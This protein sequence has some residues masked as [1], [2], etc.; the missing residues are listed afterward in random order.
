M[1]FCAPHSTAAYLLVPPPS[2]IS[3]TFPFG[4]DCPWYKVQADS[5]EAANGRVLSIFDDGVTYK[6]CGRFLKTT[7]WLLSAGQLIWLWPGWG[8]V[9]ACVLLNVCMC[10]DITAVIPRLSIKRV[11]MPD[12]KLGE[13]FLLMKNLW[14]RALWTFENV[15]HT[16]LDTPT[17]CV[18]SAPRTFIP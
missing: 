8:N 10:C 9:Y 6:K 5:H 17:F 14:A 1:P 7:S 15:L 11:H 18:G 2:H 3:S 16:K 13:N 4:K 12:C